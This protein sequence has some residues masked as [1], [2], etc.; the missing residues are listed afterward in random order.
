M[1]EIRFRAW[2][3]VNK[4]TNPP[5]ELIHLKGDITKDLEDTNSCLVL[6][7]FT[8]LK[9]KNGKE[10]YEGDIVKDQFGIKYEVVF[11]KCCFYGKA[12]PWNGEEDI[13][14]AHKETEIEVIGN[15]HENPELIK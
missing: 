10:I 2:D 9:D 12:D 1:R 15:I 6:M 4:E 7:Q 11:N 5:E 14:L 13:D 8:G 3:S